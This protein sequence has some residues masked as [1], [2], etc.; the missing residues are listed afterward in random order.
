MPDR[1]R[2]STVIG[3]FP[4]RIGN[5]LSFL[6]RNQCALLNRSGRASSNGI[7]DASHLRSRIAL[8]DPKLAG[9]AM[10]ARKEES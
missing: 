4:T 2:N 7:H 3:G 5:I 8:Q 1:R 9:P 10:S 6:L